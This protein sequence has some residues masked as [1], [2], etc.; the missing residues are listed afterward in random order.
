VVSGA[1]IGVD[2]KALSHDTLTAFDGL[3]HQRLF[4]ALLIQH[5][6]RGGDHDLW[7][8]GFCL[9]CFKERIT[10]LRNIVSA[11]DVLY[12]ID[13]DTADR[14]FDRMLGGTSCDIAG[15]RQHI[16]STGRRSITVIDNEYHAVGLVEDLMTDAADETG[17]PKTT[18]SNYGNGTLAV[19]PGQW[20]RTRAAYAITDI[21]VTEVERLKRCESMAS[22][23]VTDM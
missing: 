17:M 14:L 19:L 3:A 7:S 10:H 22:D 6:F 9:Q 5:A 20:R 1:G 4:P 21:G 23:V 12:P 16:L 8:V 11:R 13:A 18:V 2:T 15:G